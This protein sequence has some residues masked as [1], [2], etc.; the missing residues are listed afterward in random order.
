MKST[1]ALLAIDFC[2]NVPEVTIRI[3]EKQITVMILITNFNQSQQ[4]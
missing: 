4:Y 3:M 2:N 1:I